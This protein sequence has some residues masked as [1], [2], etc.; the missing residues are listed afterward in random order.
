ML[1]EFK[2]KNFKC[3]DE[4]E[5]KNLGKINILLGANNVGKTTFLEAVFGF[6]CGRNISRFVTKSILRDNRALVNDS[7]YSNVE[8]ILNTL[9]NKKKSSFSFEGK[10]SDYEKQFSYNFKFSPEFEKINQNLKK[11]D[12]INEIDTVDFNSKFL[13]KIIFSENDKKISEDNI[14][15]PYNELRLTVKDPFIVAN[16][17]DSSNLKKMSNLNVIYSILKRDSE[18]FEIL[19]RELSKTFFCEIESIDILAYPDGMPAPVSIKCKNREYLPIYEFGEGMQRWFYIIGSQ[20]IYKNNIF[21]IDEIGDSLH[22]E[23]QKNLGL[24]I[25]KFCLE[26]GNQIFATTQSLEFVKNF[27][28]QIQD[29]IS[30]ILP[31]VRII[32]LKN[33]EGK[34]KTRVLEGKKALN[35][36][37]ENGMELR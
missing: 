31:E 20:L 36:I 5:I 6:A 33:V 32:T 8:K 16:L 1:H 35:L 27:L 22:P 28:I 13:S 11:E 15:F 25:A 21:L 14:F 17:V 10:T 29:K 37:I 30:D 4:F 34:V 2:I 12:I 19:K 26:N 24:N 18:K 9:T 7:Y 23:A 3:F